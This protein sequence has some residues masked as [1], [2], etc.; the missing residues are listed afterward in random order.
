MIGPNS[1]S[2]TQLQLLR[3][4]HDLPSQVSRMERRSDQDIRIDN[5]LAELA[6]GAF[7]A[8][9]GDQ[10]VT[11]FFQPAGDTELVFGGSEE[12]GLF[13]C[14]LASIIEYEKDLHAFAR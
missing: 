13:L 1:G 3:T 10:G 2:D 12:S 6:V 5:L 4:V 7:L 14:R 11:L 8:R 9:G